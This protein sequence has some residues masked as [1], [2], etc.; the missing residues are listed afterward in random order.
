[1]EPTTSGPLFEIRG[2]VEHA[3]GCG[4]SREFGSVTL[5][6]FGLVASVRLGH[7]TFED[8]PPGRYRLTY[9]PSCNPFGCT[10]TVG[11]RIVDGDGYASFYRSSCVADC[12]IDHAV[13]IAELIQCLRQA[14]DGSIACRNCDPDR[15]GRVT[16]DE[17]LQAIH[18][19]F[20]GC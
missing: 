2:C 8:V 9:S 3:R 18:A 4:G 13:S 17:L 16:V 19:I 20:N 5:Q 6:P 11:V 12:S 14:L 1:M 7:F 15:N 10:G